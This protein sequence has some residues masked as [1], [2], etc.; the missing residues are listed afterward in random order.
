MKIL[1][2]PDVLGI[3]GVS[4][5]KL[6]ADIKAGEFPSP[7][8]LGARAVGWIDTGIYDWI[9]VRAQVARKSGAKARMQEVT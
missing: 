3:I 1:R 4:R 7:I 6:Y 2:L 8:S 9:D 5:S